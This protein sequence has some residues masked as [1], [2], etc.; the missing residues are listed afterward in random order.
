MSIKRAE[1]FMDFALSLSRLSKC[2][3][4]SV[5]AVIT[6]KKLTQIYSIGVNGGPAGLD[7]CMCNT[8]GKYGCI[9][10]EINAL[11]KCRTE[12]EKKVMFITLAPCKQCAAAIINAGFTTVYYAEAWKESAG[13]HLLKSAGINVIKGNQH[14]TG[15]Y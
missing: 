8:E 10:A 2:E 6:D 12:D 5:A 13:I 1:I 9:H 4:R 11:I 7:Q 14:N 3:E 15:T